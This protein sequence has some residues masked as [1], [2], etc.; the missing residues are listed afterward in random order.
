MSDSTNDSDLI[1]TSRTKLLENIDF[2][3]AMTQ[4]Q[5]LELA[6]IMKQIKYKKN[7]IVINQGDS[8]RSLFIV[9]YGRLKAYATDEEGNQTIFSFFN[10]GNYFGELS[11]LDEAPRSATVSTLEDCTLLTIDHSMFKDF[12]D[13]HPSACWSL[14]RSLTTN[15]RIMDETICSLTSNDIHGRLI[16]T[17]YKLA[18]EDI[19]GQLVTPKLTH[20]DYAEM[21]GSSREMVSRIFKELKDDNYIS[22]EKKQVSILKRLPNNK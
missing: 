6:G 18:E 21:I 19:N 15:I 7:T 14:F 10:N 22:V 17:I 5:L 12:V 13:A 4:A 2:F 9:V 20:Q 8:S 3:R 11:L 1:L 16:A